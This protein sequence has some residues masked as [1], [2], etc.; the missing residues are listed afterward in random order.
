[1]KRTNFC[2]I[3]LIKEKPECAA[4]VRA[5]LAE[6]VR[7]QVKSERNK[8]NDRQK[9]RCVLAPL[10][11]NLEADTV[12]F[13]ARL[14]SKEAIE[15]PAKFFLDERISGP[16]APIKVPVDVYSAALKDLGSSFAADE[17]RGLIETDHAFLVP[18]RSYA[19]ERT[20]DFLL[21]ENRIDESTLFALLYLDSTTPMYSKTRLQLMKFIPNSYSSAPSL[22]EKLY[23]EAV[24]SCNSADKSNSTEEIPRTALTQLRDFW[25]LEK[26]SDNPKQAKEHLQRKASKLLELCRSKAASVEHVKAWLQLAAQ[27]RLEIQ[28]AQTSQN[29]RGT[30]LEG[31]LGP[32][33]FRRIF[34]EYKNFKPEP[35]KFVL[36]QDTALLR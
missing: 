12:E 34:P 25:D 4:T 9:L 16:Q 11:M 35:N 32:G 23:A 36:D 18:V 29:P 22:K 19:D 15:I 8:E 24:E 3:F 31:G 14:Q 5:S 7:V 26:M 1:M 17:T 2:T 21:E 10:E 30:I 13:D 33:G 27:R 6:A 28:A 20:I